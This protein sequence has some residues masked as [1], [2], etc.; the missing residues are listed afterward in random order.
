MGSNDSFREVTSQSWF[1][2]LGASIKSVGFGI[3]LFIAA[4]PVLFMNEGCAV[5]IAK[6]LEEGAGKVISLKEAKV[7]SANN[8][9]LVH[10]TGEAT[11]TD[12]VNDPVLGISENAIRIIRTVQMYQWKEESS[13]KTEKKLGGGTETVTEYRYVK[14]WSSSVINSNNFRRSGYTN[15][16]AMEISAETFNAQN[17]TLGDFSLPKGLIDQITQG[18]PVQM[19]QEKLAALPGN[20]QGRAQL[21]GNEIYVGNNPASPQ[22]GDLK[23]SVTV[24]KPQNVSI[25]AQ[26]QGN[27]FSPY[28][29]EQET[30]IFMLN[31]GTVGAAQMF[32]QA[33]SSNRTRTWIVRLVGFIL[34]F[35]GLSMVFK[36]IVTLGDV[37]PIVG[38]ILN[39]GVSV[40]SFVVSLVLSLVTI[41]IAWI[42]YR[43]LLGIV[44]L[45]LGV[46]AFV[47]FKVFGK[48]K[49]PQAA[50]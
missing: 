16:A 5:K 13:S 31:S 39:F 9:K 41:A 23:I 10:L 40:A 32:Q 48:K 8:G 49:Q 24:V 11:T 12:T 34:M 1:S 2:R 21:S 42:F 7:D 6:G 50:A 30:T 37:V 25:V 36:P 44:L 43:P 17:V 45:V 19:T 14:D 33:Q 4:F 15:P 27:T 26:Q 35:A 18:E 38:S 20:L 29:T 28:Q 22:I 47:A 46:G 3:L